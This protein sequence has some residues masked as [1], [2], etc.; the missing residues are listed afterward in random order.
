MKTPLHR[1]APS[2]TGFEPPP[3]ALDLRKIIGLKHCPP[4]ETGED[5]AR[6][7]A[8]MTALKHEVVV[9]GAVDRRSRLVGWNVVAASTHDPHAL[10]VGDVFT[11]VM[12]TSG[13]SI[14]L[15]RNSTTAHLRTSAREFEFIRNVSEAAQLLGYTL[16]DYI[17]LSRKVWCSLLETPMVEAHAPLLN[18]HRVELAKSGSGEWQCRM[19]RKSNRHVQPTRPVIY[20]QYTT[21]HCAHCRTFAWLY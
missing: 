7:F 18:L 3:N 16:L 21:T 13:A 2:T 6:A 20:G 10:R 19:C 11:P 12:K 14:V 9:S 5:V 15:V 17:V 8:E 4:L 1:Y